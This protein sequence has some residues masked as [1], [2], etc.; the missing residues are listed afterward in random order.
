MKVNTC[1]LLASLSV[2]LDQNTGMFA[3]GPKPSQ[4]FSLSLIVQSGSCRTS[5]LISITTLMC[6]SA[7]ACP[8]HLTKSLSSSESQRH[9]SK[10]CFPVRSI[11][12]W[13]VLFFCS[14]GAVSVN[15]P[16]CIRLQNAVWDLTVIGIGL[17]GPTHFSPHV[18]EG[19]AFPGP[20][21]WARGPVDWNHGE[22]AVCCH[23]EG[24][25]LG[26][27]WAT[28]RKLAWVS[29]IATDSL[30]P[31][32]QAMVPPWTLTSWAL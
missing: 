4:P 29:G 20:V 6:A 19:P 10:A 15:Y 27:L 3:E 25:E 7:S 18:A 5:H 30:C 13:F 28:E 11:L 32:G 17:R 1:R 8:E 22:H 12:A 23:Q 14:W 26:H 24:S 9:R 16:K 2:Q 21:W 31:L